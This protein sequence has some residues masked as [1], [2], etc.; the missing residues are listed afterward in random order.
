MTAGRQGT[1]KFA[2]LALGACIQIGLFCVLK[3][4]R[5]HRRG[6]GTLG[7]AQPPAFTAGNISRRANAT[8][9]TLAPA[10]IEQTP[11]PHRTS[12]ATIEQ[13]PHRTSNATDV[14]LAPSTALRLPGV[15]ATDPVVILGFPFLHELDILHIKL[16]LL[17]AVVSYFVISESCF[18]QRGRPKPLH[19]NL[20]KQQ[21]RFQAYAAQIWHIV[22]CQPPDSIDDQLG[23][24][25]TDKV[26]TNI[27]LALLAQP[28]IHDASVVII[29][30]SDEVPG[31]N[32]VRWLRDQGMG[33]GVTYEFEST[34]PHYVYG[35]QWRVRPSG[36]STTTAR[37]ARFE[38]LFWTAKLTGVPFT[39]RVLGVPRSVAEGS[40][41]CSY[42]LGHEEIVEKLNAANTVDGPL[43]LGR[44]HWDADTLR[45]LN[46]CG[47]TPQGDRCQQVPINLSA[48]SA[49]YPYLFHTPNCTAF[50]LP[51]QRVAP[52]GGAPSS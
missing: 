7:R 10:T 9:A 33:M 21:P 38:R 22:D 1:K 4:A 36:Y 3:V 46:G 19:F 17:S 32:A 2:V 26:K 14:T 37:S 18:S 30:D 12:N 29:G 34:M 39:Q 5:T 48:Y 8:D 31:P 25:Q 50:R 44:Y 24:R 40:W 45:A 43:I 47:V 23:W 49:Q 15:P 6:G 27:G 13:N 52:D 42:C 41:H 11:P 28:R 16:Q 20:S 35:F 51:F